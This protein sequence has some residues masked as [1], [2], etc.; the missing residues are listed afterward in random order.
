MTKQ[1]TILI[2]QKPQNYF[3]P[4]YD[5]IVFSP[6]RIS[7]R[8]IFYLF[9]KLLYLLHIPACS[10]FWGDWKKHIS[11]AK[12]V[13]IFDYGYQRGMETYIHKKNPSCE[14]YLFFWN[15]ISA[16]QKNHKLFTDP[17]MIFSTDLMDCI[18]YNFHYNSLF[19]PKPAKKKQ[20]ARLA[21]HKALFIG[22]N[23]ERHKQ[24]LLLKHFLKKAD[25]LCDIRI[26][27]KGRKEQKEKKHTPLFISHPVSYTEY[28]TALLSCDLLLDIN[29]KGQSALTLRVMEAV[30]FS[31]KLIT[32]NTQ[33]QNYALYN[34]NNIL[35]LPSDS[36]KWE[37]S[38][39]TEFLNK[40]F[41]PYS[42]E[43]SEYYDFPSWINRFSTDPAV[44]PKPDETHF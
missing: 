7:E 40:P 13:I 34:P 23:K 32:T 43:I 24:L 16:K 21:Q 37:L 6:F 5:D 2:Y 33:I 12:K 19:Y 35:I 3:F 36:S 26:V 44:T 1:D 38:V 29:Q 18:R 8:S 41:V 28:L 15:T 17:S 9:Y 11:H 14:V 39:L 42:P 27:P 4:L 22:L 10:Y 20:T 30:C 31:K 25:I